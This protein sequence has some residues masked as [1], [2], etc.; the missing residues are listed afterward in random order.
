M[1]EK[2]QTFWYSKKRVLIKVRDFTGTSTRSTNCATGTTPCFRQN[3]FD[4]NTATTA[5]SGTAVIVPSLAKAGFKVGIYA[6]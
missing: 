5:P 4:A 6:F 2:L 1:R 3:T